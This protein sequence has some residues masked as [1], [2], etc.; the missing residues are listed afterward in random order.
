MLCGVLLVVEIRGFMIKYSI[1]K[2]FRNFYLFAGQD[3]VEPQ[4]SVEEEVVVMR[5]G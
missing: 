2:M 5:S 1:L 4:R 3:Q